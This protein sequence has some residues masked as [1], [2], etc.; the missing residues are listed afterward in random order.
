MA[1]QQI[2]RE[3]LRAAIR[4]MGNGY[5]FLM[6]DAA[7]TVLPQDTLSTLVKGFLNSD[8]PRP[9]DEGKT[10]LLEQI[11]TFRK[12]SLAGEYYEGFAVNSRNCTATSSGTLAVLCRL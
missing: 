2:D 3:K 6:V 7:I 9:D 5:L 1:G 12:A 10:S 8:E 11:K 4:R